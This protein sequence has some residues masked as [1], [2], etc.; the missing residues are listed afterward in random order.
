[1]VRNLDKLNKT[2]AFH[3]DS[4]IKNRI[5]A[6]G[7]SKHPEAYNSKSLL[8]MYEVGKQNVIS[9]SNKTIQ[10]INAFRAFMRLIN[11]FYSLEGLEDVTPEIFGLM[12][13]GFERE[14]AKSFNNESTYGS[15]NSQYQFNEHIQLVNQ[16][17][18]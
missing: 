13:I 14:L 15:P 8:E 11:A 9:F 7:A 16:L 3:E 2:L 18:K 17:I 6:L 4:R 5:I 10:E 12:Q 1:V